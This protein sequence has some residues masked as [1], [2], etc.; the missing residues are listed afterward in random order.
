MTAEKMPLKTISDLTNAHEWLFNQQRGGKIDPKTADALNTT[1]KG[2]VYL[3][4]TLPAKY[5][6]LWFKSQIKK[7][8]FPKG[9]LPEL[10]GG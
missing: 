7:V 4:A 3:R 5:A 1:L 8:D 2:A 9:M 6:D 10:A